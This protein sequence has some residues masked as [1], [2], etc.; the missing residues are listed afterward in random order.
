MDLPAAQRLV[1]R[2]T[3]QADAARKATI[4]ADV[5]QV[6]VAQVDVARAGVDPVDAAAVVAA[7]R[8]PY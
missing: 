3:A 4:P 6:D 1:T 8:R 5:A 2:A 7:A